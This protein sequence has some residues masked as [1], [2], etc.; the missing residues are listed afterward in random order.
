[1]IVTVNQTS[2]STAAKTEGKQTSMEPQTKIISGLLLRF[3]QF[4][5]LGRVFYLV[6]KRSKSLQEAVLHFKNL[7]A[8][9][10]VNTG[11]IVL[12]K[13]T[14]LGNQY[15]WTMYAPFFPSPQFDRL[16]NQEL[17]F[18]QGIAGVQNPLHFIFLSITKKCP[19]QCEH[20]FEWDKM[21][22]PEKLSLQD[23]KDIVYKFQQLN[24]STVFITGGEPLSRYKD[25]IE[26]ISYASLENKVWVFTS[27]YSLT[28]E[29]AIEMKQ[30]GLTGVLISFDH[31]IEDK[32]NAFRGNSKSFEKALFA[33]QNAQLAGLLTAISVCVTREFLSVENLEAY[34]EFAKNLNVGFVQFLEPKAE[35]RYKNEDVLLNADQIQVL[36]EF[37]RNFNEDKKKN[38]YPTII[39][40]G[41]HQRKLGCHGGGKRF[42]YVD[43]NGDMQSCPFCSNKMGSA[44]G[45][46]LNYTNGSCL[47]YS[48]VS[49]QIMK[50]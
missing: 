17:D 15:G 39:Y 3:Y 30:S 9:K 5:I 43:S 13:Y 31:F 4:R 32:H 49:N 21:H 11:D 2:V 42:L 50:S 24:I 16:I 12:R 28:P 35:G 36:E 38:Q 10:K 41:Y 1:M 33:L 47:Q 44:L 18:A 7:R 29:R 19:L 45:D 23:L 37:Y 22:A 25:L 6:S 46:T 14:Q 26:L 27:G 34:M 8:L 48:N 20:C 40:Q